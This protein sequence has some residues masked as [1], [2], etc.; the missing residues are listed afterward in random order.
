MALYRT[1][2]FISESVAVLIDPLLLSTLA[3]EPSTVMSSEHEE[4]RGC[5]VDTALESVI[6]C[7]KSE[8]VASMSGLGDRYP[9]TSSMAGLS[10]SILPG[11]FGLPTEECES[12]GVPSFAYRVRGG[13][14]V[15]GTNVFRNRGQRISVAGARCSWQ[16]YLVDSLVA[17]F[18][19]VYSKVGGIMSIAVSSLFEIFS[20]HEICVIDPVVPGNIFLNA[21][22]FSITDDGSRGREIL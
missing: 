14:S 19:S 20:F 1:G 18:L 9:A 13:S 2:C 3:C 8:P 5:A 22:A 11:S 4:G 15:N 6:A 12:A 21:G 10:L 16:Y 17:I 7:F